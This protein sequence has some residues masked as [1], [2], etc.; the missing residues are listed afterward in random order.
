MITTPED[1][2]KRLEE[3]E[4]NP[5]NTQLAIKMVNEE[6]ES[7][8][9]INADT[10]TI[11][12]PKQFQ[13]G[14]AIYRDHDS[15]TIYFE[16][17]RY[18]DSVDL[19]NK[20]CIIQYINANGGQ[21]VFSVT[22]KYISDDNKKVIFA[23]DLSNN[24]TA[25]A[26]QVKFS[27]RF[28]SL[29]NNVYTYNWGT[30]TATIT[31]GEGLYITDSGET[32][33]SGDDITQLVEKINGIYMNGG[34][35][36]GSNIDYNGLNNRPKINH[37][38]LEGDLLSEDLHLKATELPEDVLRTSNV[39]TDLNENSENPVQNKAITKYIRSHTSDISDLNTRLTTIEEEFD[40]LTYVPLEVAK[41]Q[42]RPSRYYGG[43][44]LFNFEEEN[45][46]RC[47]YTLNDIY[48]NILFN[49]DVTSA[50][51]ISDTEGHTDSK[52]KEDW[53]K[54]YNSTN[55]SS[56]KVLWSSTEPKTITFTLNAADKTS[57][58]T[59]E[60]KLTFCYGL[61]YGVSKPP[62]ALNSD[63]I[64]TLTQEL[65]Y[66]ADNF[67]F[68]VTC[69]NE[70]YIYIAIPQ[71]RGGATNKGIVDISVG[72]FV[73]GFEKINE[74]DVI[75]YDGSESKQNKALYDI[76]RSTNSNLGYTTVTINERG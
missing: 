54:G 1:Y 32:L 23:W 59:A 45:F 24:V 61:F 44:S 41:F 35:G 5:I 19:Y 9:I 71:T 29:E 63:F 62:E 11:S 34:L 22:D 66:D 27:V 51:T 68:S 53:A 3:I 38:T 28:F 36:S 37:I 4:K 30:R 72:G 12:I 48:F 43:A 20:S 74:V 26:G 8:F 7:K 14:A 21:Y 75:W 2:K 17:D 6:T 42:N 10:R 39:D 31:I 65:C 16:I 55:N 40:S 33:P 58:V 64:Q 49:K 47:G 18:F 69:E 25:Y 70:Q 52:T 13:E 73:G 60:T 46:V 76:Y 56:S 50:I 57:T 15:E 67:N